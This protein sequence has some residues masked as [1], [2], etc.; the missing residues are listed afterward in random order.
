[1]RIILTSDLHYNV[2]RSKG[3]TE[4]LAEEIRRMGGDVLVF[5]GDSAG[6]ELEVLDQVFAL[7]DSFRGVKMAVA[8]NHELWTHPNSEFRTRNANDM[9][10]VLQPPGLPGGTIQSDPGTDGP[11]D[12]LARY[13][14]GMLEACRRHGVHYLDDSPMV[15]GGVG[16]VGSVGWYDF[17]FRPSAM[18]IPLRFYQHK[19]GP[20][21]AAY[22]EKHGHL[23][24]DDSDVPEAAREVTSRWM[25]G[26]RVRLPMSDVEFTQRL[27]GKLRRHLEQVHDSAETVVAAVHHLPFAALVPPALNPN[28]AFAAGFLGSELIGETLMEFPKVRHVYCGHS[29]RARTCRRGTLVCRSIGSTYRAKAYEVLDL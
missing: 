22:F 11:E 5:A 4:A 17:S 13:E 29:H 18:K 6:S 8:G 20:G 7:F 9:D 26:E 28:W 10:A 23:L 15:L 27:A 25:D 19:V 2:A 3:P 24:A 14:R 1:M 21:A 12:S 16:F